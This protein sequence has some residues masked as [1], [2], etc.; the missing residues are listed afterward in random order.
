MDAG[1]VHE[2][3]G[4]ACTLHMLMWM[5]IFENNFWSSLSSPWSRLGL[6]CGGK[7][8]GSGGGGGS[9]G[10]GGGG[11]SALFMLLLVTA[12]VFVSTRCRFELLIVGCHF[13]DES[14]FC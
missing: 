13:E 5:L 11:D 7:G 10:S 1:H 9:G 3:T 4:A 12:V 14:S 8:S 2:D 6:R